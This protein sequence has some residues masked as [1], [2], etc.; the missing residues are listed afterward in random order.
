M[1]SVGMGVLSEGLRGGGFVQEEVQV[2]WAVAQ[3]AGSLLDGQLEY[4]LQKALM[5]LA[6]LGQ[7]STGG[8][9]PLQLKLAAAAVLRSVHSIYQHQVDSPSPPPPQTTPAAYRRQKE[10]IFCIS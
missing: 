4:V 5:V 2:I 1:A 9:S 6:V 10:K 7:P 8:R 3:R